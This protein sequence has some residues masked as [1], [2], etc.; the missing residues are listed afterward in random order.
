MRDRCKELG[1]PISIAAIRGW[2]KPTFSSTFQHVT[3]EGY[4]LGTLENF[5]VLISRLGIVIRYNVIKKSVEILVPG[6]SFSLDNKDNVALA[7]I[8]SECAKVRM[9]STHAI[10]FVLCVADENQYNPV[11]SWIESRP[12]DGI[13]RLED[14]YAT[15]VSDAPIKAT[16]IRKWLVQC[17]AAACMP[18][19]ISAQGVLVFSG[20]QNLGKTTWFQNLAPQALDVVLTGHSLDT[21]NKDSV[22]TA[23]GHWIVELGE[24]DATFKKS[25]IAA[26]KAFITQPTDKLRRPYAAVESHMPRRTVLGGSVNEPDFLSD[27]TGNRR[28]WTVAVEAFKFD[29]GVDMQQ[30]WAEVLLLA[31]GG[32][33]WSLD[34]VELD[35]LSVHNEDFTAPDVWVERVTTTFAWAN[36]PTD[37]TGWQEATATQIAAL[38]GQAQ[39][40]SGDCRRIS[41]AVRKLNGNRSRLLDG[42]RRLW[43]PTE[44][45]G[46]VGFEDLS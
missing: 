2:L 22:F 4:P 34:K 30:V 31:Q 38:C 24:L 21:R 12:W 5:R 42:V 17:A 1:T 18:Y 36:A 25:D 43:I 3:D 16:L 39:V 44:S 29:H 14:F 27:P 13:S 46:Q 33:G 41:Q 19:G 23:V 15:V 35:Q 26:L 40:G 45:G 32:E 20:A 8:L 10:Q 7:H 37:G 6:T 9:P 11:L 28:F